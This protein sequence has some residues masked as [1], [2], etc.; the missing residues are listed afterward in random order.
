MSGTHG[1]SLNDKWRKSFLEA[2]K[3]SFK[4]DPISADFAVGFGY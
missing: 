2:G 1:P 4:G 3:K